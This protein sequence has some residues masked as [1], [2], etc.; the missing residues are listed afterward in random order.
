MRRSLIGGVMVF[1]P[2]DLLSLYKCN[3]GIFSNLINHSTQSLSLLVFDVIW[4]NVS[5]VLPQSKHP[6]YSGENLEKNKVLYTRL[7]M[8]SK[9]YGCTPAQLALSW[10]LHQGEDVVPIPGN[11]LTSYIHML[12][13][14]IMFMFYSAYEQGQTFPST[15]Q[16]WKE[17]SVSL[18]RKKYLFFSFKF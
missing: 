3:T 7:E 12:I 6:R 18:V 8:L 17:N 16:K 10:V 14:K 2:H 4:V 15:N 1:K 9:K 5:S 13:L 11:V